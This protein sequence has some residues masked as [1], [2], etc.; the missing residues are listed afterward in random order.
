MKTTDVVGSDPYLAPEILIRDSQGNRACDPRL[1]D[2]WSVGIMF[3]CMILRRFPWRIADSRADLCF[4][5]F[6]RKTHPLKIASPLV[7]SSSLP[8]KI[9]LS[10]DQQQEEE[11][12]EVHAK[13]NSQ[14]SSSHSSHL[15]EQQ[16]TEPRAEPVAGA[17]VRLSRS[18]C[19]LVWEPS[20]LAR[21]D[22]ELS[23]KDTLFRLLPKESR[24]TIS[25]MLRVAVDQRIR[26]DQLLFDNHLV[27]PSSSSSSSSDNNTPS[28]KTPL[29]RLRDQQ[30]AAFNLSGLGWLNSIHTCLDHHSSS[31]PAPDHDHVLVGSINSSKS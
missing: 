19:P 15:G 5:E 10:E 27:V 7:V 31:T 28:S 17:K 16:Q 21:E 6:V 23:E 3:V 22:D 2:V 8:S 26:F 9:G 30:I 1:V 29:D 24:L 20:E 13:S 14:Q 18:A 12:E 4:R 11:E 25:R